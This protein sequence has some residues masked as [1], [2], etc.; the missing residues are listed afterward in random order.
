MKAEVACDLVDRARTRVDSGEEVQPGERGNR[1][2]R[3]RRSRRGSDTG[4]SGRS[5]VRASG[6]E[7]PKHQRPGRS[8]GLRASSWQFPSREWSLGKGG[9][10]TVPCRDLKINRAGTSHLYYDSQPPRSVCARRQGG[11][12]DEKISSRG[13]AGGNRGDRRA[14][15]MERRRRRHDSALE[16]GR[17]NGRD[18]ADAGEGAEV[19]RRAGEVSPESGR[20]SHSAR[21]AD[22]QV[23]PG[24]DARTDGGRWYDASA[25]QRSSRGRH[26]GRNVFVNDPC[27]DPSP[28]LPFPAN[29][30]RTVQSETE[31]AVLNATR[32]RRP[33][34]TTTATMATVPGGTDER[35]NAVTGTQAT[36]RDTTAATTTTAIMTAATRIIITMC[37]PAGR[38][39]PATTTRT[40]LRQP[41]GP[42][43]LFLFDRRRR[44]MDRRRRASPLL[45]TGRPGRHHRQRRVFRRSGRHVASP[46]ADV[47]LRVAL[48]ECGRRRHAQRQ[49]R[50]SS[51]VAPQQVPVESFANTRCEGNPA[52]HGYRSAGVRARA[53]HLGTAGRGR[54]VIGQSGDETISSTRNGCTSIRRPGSC[55]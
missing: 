50:A 31:I 7:A 54:A 25:S 2:C 13:G 21:P 37:S 18:R 36:V 44:S 55:T 16:G 49:P 47:L 5:G 43:R 42:Q 45:P 17:H 6:R 10:G 26:A 23:R 8:A 30:L 1:A 41:P 34:M 32:R 28:T 48:P 19:E 4:E 9:C 20:P 3:G 11:R 29:Y 52:L 22:S 12:A 40:A 53:H 39:S 14:V 51:G 38:W 33:T 24:S 15:R 46:D 27:L 35:A